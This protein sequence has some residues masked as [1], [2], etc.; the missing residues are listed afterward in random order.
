MHSSFRRIS[1][2]LAPY[3][4]QTVLLVLGLLLQQAFDS[5]LPLAFKFLIDDAILP[6]NFSLLLLIL[7]TLVGS[8][9]LVA[10]AG[11][12]RDYLYSTLSARVLRDLIR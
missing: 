10:A 3:R 8:A 1:S 7:S 11:I 4:W 9:A 5:L 2:L 6:R 12:G